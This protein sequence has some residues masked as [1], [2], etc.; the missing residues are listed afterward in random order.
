M[1]R[2][3]GAFG[4]LSLFLASSCAT[5]TVGDTYPVDSIDG[6][7]AKS[8]D[9]GDTIEDCVA[10]TATFDTGDSELAVAWCPDYDLDSYI[11]ADASDPFFTG[12][13]CLVLVEGSIPDGWLNV[14][15]TSDITEDCDDEDSDVTYAD[16]DGYRDT[17]G[18]GYGDS[19]SMAL[20]CDIDG[21]VTVGGDCDDGDSAI[22]P[23]AAEV[24]DDVDNNCDGAIDDADDDLE[25]GN[26]YYED[27]DGD[28]YGDSADAV[29]ACEQPEGWVEDNTDCDDGDSTSNPD[30]TEICDDVDNDCDGLH[31]DEDDSLLIVTGTQSWPD[32]DA[33]GYGSDEA[34]ATWSCDIPSGSVDNNGDCDDGDNGI[35]PGA[36]DILDDGIDQDC[37]GADGTSDTDTDVDGDGYTNEASGGNDCDDTNAAVNP[38]AT[39]VSLDGVDNNCDGMA[40]S[41]D[42][43]EVCGDPIDELL[44]YTW[45][46][47]LRPEGES[48]WD[49]V[50]EG[51]DELCAEVSL[52]DGVSLFVQGPFDRDGD[53]TFDEDYVDATTGDGVWLYQGDS[54]VHAN[55]FTANGV[56]IP[57]T[58]YDW[59]D[60]ID[61]LWI[62]DLM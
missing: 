52:D 39:E 27:N 11:G 34:D 40:N 23:A 8:M 62:V 22:N 43:I 29:I 21:Y 4:L 14:A 9:P 16:T 44:L 15:V 12:C 46:L 20:V 56:I 32:A 50:A 17:D 26:V 38:G 42:L 55:G 35:N 45:Q 5:P 6:A 37:S 53:G 60:S 47:W 49:I 33:D 2:I 51:M 28:T 30:A 54:T 58:T 48:D 3:S 24:C 36:E 25:G 10:E 31:N 7:V 61:G 57:M 1:T 59:G 13:L 19:D 18:D 41:D